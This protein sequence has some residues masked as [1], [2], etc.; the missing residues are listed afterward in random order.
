LR[1]ASNRQARIMFSMAMWMAVVVTPLQIAAGDT[2]GLNTLRYQPAKIAAIE[3]EYETTKPAPLILVGIPD[4]KAEVNRYAIEVPLLGSI[5]LT[6]TLDGELKGLKTFPRDAR[7][8]ALIP[9]FTFRLMVGLGLLI[10]GLGIWSLVQRIRHRLYTDRLLHRAAL[11][12][13]PAG[14]AAV[15]AGWYTTETGRQPFTVYGLLKTADSLSPVSAPAVGASLV[16][17][18]IVYFTVFGAGIFYIVRLMRQP[19]EAG[20]EELDHGPTR[21]AGI[22]PAQQIADGGEHGH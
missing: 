9:F 12:M 3:G 13:G 8:D 18:I 2:L 22:T 5:I 20:E 7:P 21:T 6:H 17:F 19:P 10:L 14:F 16:A 11:V 1:N 15:L 4:D